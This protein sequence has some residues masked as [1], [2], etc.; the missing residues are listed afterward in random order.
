MKDEF[1][2]HKVKHV[3]MQQAMGKAAY[4][5]DVIDLA[6]YDSCTFFVHLGDMVNTNGVADTLTISMLEGSSTSPVG[7]VAAE[8]MI[9]D[10]NYGLIMNGAS[11]ALDDGVAKYAYIGG[12]RYI[13]FVATSGGTAGVITGPMSVVAMLGKAAHECAADIEA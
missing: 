3:Y 9:A 5:S 4:T 6:G 7:A 8:D 1:H 10:E 11:N 2:N 12:Y 13:K